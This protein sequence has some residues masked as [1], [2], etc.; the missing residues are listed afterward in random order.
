VGRL[1]PRVDAGLT[2]AEELLDL[3]RAVAR[4]QEL[5]DDLSA[6]RTSESLTSGPVVVAV[7]A[8]RG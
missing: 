3:D 1:A 7:S 2:P 6:A 5:A 8:L 4:A